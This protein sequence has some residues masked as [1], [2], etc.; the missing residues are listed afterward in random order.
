MSRLPLTK[1]IKEFQTVSEQLSTTTDTKEMMRLGKA[2]KPLSAQYELAVRIQKIE[3]DLVSNNNDIGQLGSEKDDAEMKAMLTIENTGLKSEQEA[4]ENELLAYLAPTDPKDSENVIIEL[5]AGAGG[6]EASLFVGELLTSY[7]IMA[8]EIGLSFK[9]IESSNGTM[10]G[11]KEIVAEIKGDGAFSWYKYEGGV[12][13]VQRVPTTEKQ[14]RVHTSTISVAVMPLIESDNEFK[15]NPDDIEIIISTSSGNGGQSVNTTYSAVRM[16]HKP[17]GLEAQSQDERDQQQNRVKALN[18]LTSRVFDLY[19]QE[20]LAKESEARLAQVGKAD[21]SEKIRTYNFPQD[22]LTDHRY[23][24][25][26]NQLPTIMS[27][28]MKNVVEDIKKIEA[29]RILAEL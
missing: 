13:R 19:E 28:G 3:Q 22:R 7:R 18:V 15:L 25:N 1:I 23:N 12:H 9:A 17:T 10:G 29:E 20:R 5:R 4:K 21:R 2:M 27:G 14:G 6:D 8:G 26:W 11:Y 16:K 24:Q